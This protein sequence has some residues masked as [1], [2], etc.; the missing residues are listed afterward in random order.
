[1]K[2]SRFSLIRI[3]FLAAL[4][5]LGCQV[6]QKRPNPVE[7]EYVAP[8]A[9]LHR[10]SISSQSSQ[11]RTVFLLAEKVST[12]P[13]NA[14]PIAPIIARSFGILQPLGIYYY[15]ARLKPA[16]QRVSTEGTVSSIDE[17]WLEDIRQRHTTDSKI[18][19][20]IVALRVSASLDRDVFRLRKNRSIRAIAEAWGG[21]IE[22]DVEWG[23]EESVSTLT[24][25]LTVQEVLHEVTPFS[26]QIKADIYKESNGTKLALFVYGSGASVS[27]EVVLTQ[28]L[29]DALEACIA[30]AVLMLCSRCIDVDYSNYLDGDVPPQPRWIE[31]RGRI[32]KASIGVRSSE[33]V[34][35]TP[36]P[37][38]EADVAQ[39]FIINYSIETSED[40]LRR[41]TRSGFPRETDSI[42]GLQQTWI[43]FYIFYRK[44]IVDTESYIRLRNSDRKELP[45]DG[46]LRFR[47]PAALFWMIMRGLKRY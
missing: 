30:R 42:F 46:G 22:S 38:V 11:R 28:G 24:V 33:T 36:K 1:M 45:V 13:P 29:G 34:N 3:L 39:S 26:I 8:N 12:L 18:P 6:T 40:T 47:R 41:P 43:V 15:P 2:D 9:P 25:S 37:K 14:A 27:K 31:H 16:S 7:P 4:S 32:A 44:K 17:D 19:P 10:L 35:G 5:G 21:Y 20:D 23:V